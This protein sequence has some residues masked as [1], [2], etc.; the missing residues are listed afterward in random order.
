MS[1]YVCSSVKPLK[2]GFRP[3]QRQRGNG[4]RSTVTAMISEKTILL[5]PGKPYM[6]NDM[7]NA[8][9]NHRAQKIFLCL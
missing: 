2:F 9:V 8:V 7:V 1:V 3:S 6:V 5:Q 4:N